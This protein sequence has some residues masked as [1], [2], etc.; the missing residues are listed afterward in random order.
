LTKTVVIVGGEKGRKPMKN[1][2]NKIFGLAAATALAV[3]PVAVA[4][5]QDNASMQTA[6]AQ[7][8]SPYPLRDISNVRPTLA[9]EGVVRAS[10]GRIVITLWGSTDRI[11]NELR[12]AA[13]DLHAAGVPV[14]LY[15]AADTDNQPNSGWITIHSNRE[16]L[17]R[18]TIFPNQTNIRES[19]RTAGMQFA[20][21]LGTEV[22]SL[23]LGRD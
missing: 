7:M 10:T 1:V 8:N 5:A 22:A 19:T 11:R 23:S 16:Q 2:A 20:Q 14:S 9:E 17:A 4:N 12:L 6:S 18:A 15:Y 21:R 13:D 3:T